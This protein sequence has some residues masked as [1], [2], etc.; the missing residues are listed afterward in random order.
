MTGQHIV[1][2]TLVKAVHAERE[3]VHK[4]EHVIRRPQQVKAIEKSIQACNRV[5]YVALGK[6]V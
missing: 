1:D 6:S 3:I 4:R 5:A 2:I